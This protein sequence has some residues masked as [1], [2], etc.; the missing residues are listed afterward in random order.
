MMSSICNSTTTWDVRKPAPLGGESPSSTIPS[1]SLGPAGFGL[2]L[3]PTEALPNR[4]F[5]MKAVSRPGETGGRVQQTV[6]ASSIP[7][8]LLV[9]ISSPWAMMPWMAAQALPRAGFP[10]T[11]KTCSWRSIWP[12]S[13][14]GAAGKAGTDVGDVAGLLR[15]MADND[16][17]AT[18]SGFARHRGSAEAS[19]PA[20][21]HT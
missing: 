6:Q 14:H 8:G 18:R 7:H 9:M 2:G 12:A 10:T 13:R 1:V 17:R 20:G 15:K 21:T 16:A 5:E 11:S 4:A 19:Y 3:A